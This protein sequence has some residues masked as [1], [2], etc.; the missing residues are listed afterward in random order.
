L[1]P[2]CWSEKHSIPEVGEGT[3]AGHW[4]TLTVLGALTLDGLLAVMTVESPTDGEVFLAYLEQVLCPRLQPGQIVVIQDDHVVLPLLPG[5]NL[6]DLDEHE[7]RLGGD[8][9]EDCSFAL[10]PQTR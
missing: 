6:V 10:A 2:P 7:Q 5:K 3:P 4:H 8:L 1:P 9:A